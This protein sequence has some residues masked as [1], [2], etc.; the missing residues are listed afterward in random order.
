M[1]ADRFGMRAA[2]IWPLLLS[3]PAGLL[4]ILAPSV[5]GAFVGCAL[6]G[7]LVGGQH[8]VLVVHAQRLLPV[9][10]GFAA[11]LILGFT[12]ASGAIG[13]WLAGRSADA[14]GLATVM[15]WATWCAVP[16]IVLA[17]TLP[18]REERVLPVPAASQSSAD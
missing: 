5:W 8:S 13:T 9:Q 2:V 11:G 10:Q 15:Q 3:I 14:L 16:C 17:L 12:F 6:A 1:F 4:C 7:L 18:G